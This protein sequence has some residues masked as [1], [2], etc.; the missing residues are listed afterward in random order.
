MAKRAVRDVGTEAIMADAGTPYGKSQ[1]T[2]PIAAGT[3][4]DGCS[5]ARSSSSRTG[6]GVTGI[7]SPVALASPGENIGS[8][9]RP[10]AAEPEGL[11]VLQLMAKGQALSSAVMVVEGVLQKMEEQ[12]RSLAVPLSRG[13]I[14]V[15]N[16]ASLRWPAMA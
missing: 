7:S 1:E 2:V 14:G 16:V 3:P 13:G 5:I 4:E 9:S 15:K 12:A 6:S 10:A 11:E 8:I